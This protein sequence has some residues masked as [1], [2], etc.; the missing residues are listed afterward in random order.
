MR[1][2]R[3]HGSLLA[4]GPVA[5]RR[6]RRAREASRGAETL[7]PL[8]HPP[9]RFVASRRG[10]PAAAAAAAHYFLA[11]CSGG[12]AARPRA[13][14]TSRQ[15]PRFHGSL[16]NAC[17]FSSSVANQSRSRHRATWTNPSAFFFAKI[18]FWSWSKWGPVHV[19]RDVTLTTTESISPPRRTGPATRN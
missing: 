9:S 12:A 3:I 15:P 10:R 8:A 6:R 19:G 5:R 1:C 4:A 18:F 13:R 11:H 7:L 14:A 2:N 17:Q 16:R